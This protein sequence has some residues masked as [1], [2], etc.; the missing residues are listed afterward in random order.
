MLPAGNLARTASS[1]CTVEVAVSGV[2]DSGASVD[3]LVFL[4]VVP[5]IAALLAE[6]LA[7]ADHFLLELEQAVDQPLRRRRAAGDVDV[8][9]DDLVDALHHVIGAI[10]AAR[11]GAGAHGDHPLRLR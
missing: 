2:S 9:R 3:T 1:S 6:S 7:V 5:L 10:E 4:L 8:H 11:A